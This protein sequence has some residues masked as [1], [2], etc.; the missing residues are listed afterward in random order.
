MAFVPGS[1]AGKKRTTSQSGGFVPGSIAS[2]RTSLTPESG[3]FVPGSIAG[4]AGIPRVSSQQL[5]TSEGMASFAERAGLGDQAKNILEDQSGE[6]QRKIFSGGLLTDFFDVLNAT[7]YAASGLLK[8]KGI[9][10][11]IKTRQSFADEDALGGSLLGVIAGTALDIAVDP[12]TYIAPWTILKK[13]PGA[14]KVGKAAKSKVFG[15]MVEKTIE[16][17][18]GRVVQQ[19]EGGSAVGKWA[20]DKFAY[21][22]GKDPVYRKA[23]EQMEK[24]IGVSATAVKQMTKAMLDLPDEK[25]NKLLQLG[26][27]FRFERKN[28]DQ[29][30]EFLTDD[31]ITKV[32]DAFDYVD[33]LG[34]E[35]V[36]LGLLKKEVFEANKGK[37]LKSFRDKYIDESYGFAF[38]P[39]KIAKQYSRISDEEIVR[40]YLSNMTEKEIEQKFPGVLS[41]DGKIQTGIFKRDFPQ[42]FDKLFQEA[43]TEFAKGQ[44]TNP[45]YIFA[46][47]AMGMLKDVENA[48]FFNNIGSNFGTDVAQDGFIKIT[49]DNLGSLKGKY[50]PEGIAKDLDYIVNQPTDFMKGLQRATSEYKFFKVVLNPASNIRNIIS[51]KLLNHFDEAGMPL[52]RLDQ[53]YGGLKSFLKKDEWYQEVKKMG[54]TVDTFRANEIGD[55]L[56]ISGVG[57]LGG[58]YNKFKDFIGNIYQGEEMMAKMAMYKYQR[59]S[60]GLPPEK[61]WEIAERATFNYSQVTPFV[62]KM[63]SNLFGFP[64][65]TFSVKAA[66][67]I[68]KTVGKNPTKISNIGKAKQN[69]EKLAN[70]EETER[71]RAAE[72]EWVKDGFYMK[73]PFKDSEW[74]S[75]YFDL[76]YILPFGDLAALSDENNLSIFNKSPALGVIRD[77]G[78]NGD[79][80]GNKIWK[81]TD[82]PQ[83]KGADI[84]RY[85][86]K[87]IL[88]PPVADQIPGGYN[89]RTGERADYG[90]IYSSLGASEENQKRTLMQEMARMAGMKVQPIEADVQ[91]TYQEWNKKKALQTL[92]RENS[93][94]TGIG[95]FN[96]IYQKKD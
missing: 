2:Q 76:T 43:G 4:Q 67:V 37:Y 63:R 56:D 21:M 75:A 5:K 36:D 69:I 78:R 19:L 27:D 87:T 86:T 48:K 33:G 16:D 94:K 14:A 50:V 55:L 25:F 57:K 24:N 80:Y 66:P 79:Y 41:G 12:L 90:R 93:D 6:S 38:K 96:T 26:D 20:A 3:G 59:I 29:L 62:R 40:G 51:N 34:Q 92:L 91:E 28:A 46:K 68:A 17:G 11:S 81:E 9:G 85:L 18:T 22:F 47:T 32:S 65:L 15:D 53:D 60:K 64:F 7:S 88:P 10:E 42:T 44:V 77:L 83:K 89:P 30:R 73:L 72:P 13:V 95:E 1:I 39:T 82:S 49:K 8:G 35:M 71:E 84:M 61:A 70:F 45:A 74:R 23:W 54:G 52:Y 58:G 31:E